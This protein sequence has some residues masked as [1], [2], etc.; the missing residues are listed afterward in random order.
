M[1]LKLPKLAWACLKR[2]QPFLVRKAILNLFGTGDLQLF[3]KT[4]LGNIT[5]P[6]FNF[7]SLHNIIQRQ[8]WLYIYCGVCWQTAGLSTSYIIVVQKSYSGDGMF[9]LCGWGYNFPNFM[10]KRQRHTVLETKTKVSARKNTF[11]LVLQS[12]NDN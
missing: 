7:S 12:N 2:V 8:K 3:S 4:H 1:Q 11:S 5:F 10:C 9:T 6:F